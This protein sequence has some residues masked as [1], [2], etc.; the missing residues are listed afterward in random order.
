MLFKLMKQHI[1]S[2]SRSVH[3]LTTV[4]KRYSTRSIT[5]CSHFIRCKTRDI[6]P[7]RFLHSLNRRCHYVSHSSTRRKLG[8]IRL[9][10]WCC[11]AQRSAVIGVGWINLVGGSKTPNGTEHIIWK[12]SCHSASF[13]RWVH[14]FGGVGYRFWI[15][16]WV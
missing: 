9:S 3:S 1:P 12:W 11:T 2:L 8:C 13:R 15:Y 16:I 5:G 10:R 4:R 6:L 7:I 14:A